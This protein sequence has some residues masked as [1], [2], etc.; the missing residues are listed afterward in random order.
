MIRHIVTW[1]FRDGFTPE[2]NRRHAR[3][4]KTEVEALAAVIPGIISLEVIIDG[5]ASGN[6]DVALVSLFESEE[7]LTAYQVHPAH[8]RAS[9]Y[10]GTVLMNRACFD[11]V[12]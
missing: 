10:V 5:L 12:E 4:V 11:Y 8:D 7:A 3:Q 2:E 9:H 6:R 1:N